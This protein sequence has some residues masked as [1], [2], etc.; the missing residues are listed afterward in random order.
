MGKYWEYTDAFLIPW[1]LMSH[2]HVIIQSQAH[3]KLH[4]LSLFLVF[5]YWIIWMLSLPSGLIQVS[6]FTSTWQSWQ[7]APGTRFPPKCHCFGRDELQV[8]MLGKYKNINK[9]CLRHPL[10]REWRVSVSVFSQIP[11]LLTFCSHTR[12]TI[13]WFTFEEDVSTVKAKNLPRNHPVDCGE[14]AASAKGWD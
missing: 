1:G 2:C 13:L 11:V 4:Q 6:R 8:E 5:C 14:V 9:I 10:R 7:R 3:I 12:R